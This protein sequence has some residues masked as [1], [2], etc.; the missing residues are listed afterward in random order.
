M[1]CHCH[2]ASVVSDKTDCRS[3]WIPLAV[4]NESLFSCSFQYSF[5]LCFLTVWL[6]HVSVLTSNLYYFEFFWASWIFLFKFG[7]FLAIMSS[8][9]LSPLSLPSIMCMWM[10]LV[11][12]HK[13][14]R[15]FTLLRSFFLLFFRLD[16]LNLSV[17]F[18]DSSASSNLILSSFYW[19]FH[20]RN[21]TFQLQNFDLLVIIAIS[22]L[23][24]SN[25]GESVFSCFHF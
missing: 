8:N 20:L 19:I 3:Y 14:L 12:T 18:A 13:S 7:T 22:L 4:G 9:L 10:Y 11:V 25:L 21:C 1:S 16:N 23:I 15:L 6:W 24:V 17:K 2:L 5:F